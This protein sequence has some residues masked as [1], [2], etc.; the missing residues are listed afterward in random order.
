MGVVDLQEAPQA[1]ASRW[2]AIR[3]KVC[4]GEVELQA[5]RYAMEPSLQMRRRNPPM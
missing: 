4:E 1:K 5:A 3:G 2:M